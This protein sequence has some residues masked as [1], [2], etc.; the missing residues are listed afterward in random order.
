M[1]FFLE[2]CFWLT[3]ILAHPNFWFTII[4]GSPE[5]LVHHYFRFI[6][7]FGSPPASTIQGGERCG[8][9]CP[10]VPQLVGRGDHMG[11]QR[12]PGADAKSRR[13]RARFKPKWVNLALY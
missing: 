4:F 1:N 3:I 12:P 11:P 6:R 10:P 9:A 13:L 7:N 5:F 2:N 8:P